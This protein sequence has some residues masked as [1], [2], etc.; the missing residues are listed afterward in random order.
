[1]PTSDPPARGGMLRVSQDRPCPVC[2]KPDWC[3]V[4]PDGAA[5][6]CSRI[7]SPR[8][9]GEAG[10][11]HRL[12]DPTPPPARPAAAPTTDW[13]RLAATYAAALRP[14]GREKAAGMLGLPP[15]ALDCLPLLGLRRDEKPAC[16][17]F[18][19]SDAA[20]RVIGLNRRYSDGSK[21]AMPG[22]RRGLTLPTGWRDRPGPTFVVEGPTDTVALIAAGLSAVGRPSNRG[23]VQMLAELFRDLPPDREIVIVGE[24]DRKPDGTWPGL[25]GADSVAR[26]LAAA[27]R[28]PVLRT[29]PPGE[30]KDVRA[31]LTEAARGETPWPGRGEELHRLLMVSA[32]RVDPPAVAPALPPGDSPNDRDD[33]PHRLAGLFVASVTPVGS[34]PVLRYWHGEFFRYADGSYRPVPDNDLRGEITNFVR[35]E[36]VRANAAALAAHAA[37]AGGAKPAPRTK[38]VTGRLVS[39]VLQALQ[40]LCLL[41]AATEPPAWVDGATGPDPA[42]LLPM[43]SGIL[44]LDALAAG[45]PDCLLPPTPRFF[46]LNS[47]PFDFDPQAPPPREWLR[48]LAELWPDD[49]ESID[50]LQEW[51]GY[52]L[53]PDT[54]QQKILFLL[55]PKRAGKGT[56]ARVLRELIGTANTAG[57]TLGSL[58]AN[59]GLQPLLG[60]SVAIV[61]DARL[62]G[63][64]DSAVITERLL[65][66]SGEDALTVDRKHRDPITL[67]LPTRFVI[68]S[69]ELPRLGDASGALAGRLI[70]LRLIRSFYGAEDLR[71]FERLQAELPGILLWAVEGWRRL[72]HRGRFVQPASGRELVEEM[73]DLASPVGAFVRERCFV[74]P[75]E[76]VEVGDLFACWR[77]WCE[78]HGRRE[79]G[80]EQA[81]GRDLRAAVPSITKTRP[82]T[83]E[84]RLHFYHGIRLRRD[85]DPEHA[86]EH[87]GVPT[88]VFGHLGHHGHI[89][90]PLHAMLE[91]GEGVARGGARGDSP[92]AIGEHAETVGPAMRGHHDHGDQ[93]DQHRPRP[94]SVIRFRN[95]DRPDHLRDD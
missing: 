81:F 89:D 77:A 80:T 87:A 37:E 45:R 3:L 94:R 58:A 44:H 30:A 21:K 82:R 5:A 15:D 4:A 10:W 50:C 85:S 51:F 57:P 28:R 74:A 49:P 39:D 19:E 1:M 22:S 64:A 16:L 93:G 71:L 78:Q 53:T 55:G 91:K 33:D 26:G 18:P 14:E 70:L 84:G 47:L 88:P 34:P 61:S 40:G 76:R 6:I 11:L 9:A 92:R 65:S 86:G 36:L 24:N 54:R 38:A 29:L 48:F 2:G 32:V 35:A 13:P 17:T 60:K 69:N 41:P 20:G 59:F 56:I 73:E 46:A 31:W 23:G 72:R 27:L 67:K 62:S 7:E 90:Q 12:A 43:R 52:L 83:P 95:D 79:P 66:V 42:G 63:R 8:R 25:D 75:G 68:L